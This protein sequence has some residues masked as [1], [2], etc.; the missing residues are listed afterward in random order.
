MRPRVVFNVFIC[1]TLYKH[2][3]SEKYDF[4]F[5]KTDPPRR[6][7]RHVVSD[8]TSSPPRPLPRRLHHHEASPPLPRHI[9]CHVAFT[10]ASPPLP[11]R[12]R[13]HA[14][15]AA[16]SPLLPRHLCYHVASA[17]SRCCI[18]SLETAGSAFICS[19][20]TRIINIRICKFIQS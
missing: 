19:I 11:C 1:V 12:F 3:Y 4:C 9:R 18:A 7:C 10:A 5:D 2:A 14:A 15:S 17:A 8:A 6:L 13:C 16:T 20:E